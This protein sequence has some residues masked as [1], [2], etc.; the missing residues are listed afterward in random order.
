[1]LWKS[2]VHVPTSPAMHDVEPGLLGSG[3]FRTGRADDVVGTNNRAGWTLGFM[4]G[5]SVAQA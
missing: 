2:V 5:F 1:M 3:A 4:L